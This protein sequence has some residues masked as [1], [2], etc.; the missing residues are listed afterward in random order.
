MPPSLDVHVVSRRRDRSSVERFLSG[1]IDRDA[2]EDRGD[3]ELMLLPVGA[4]GAAGDASSRDWEPAVTLTRA[5][6]RGV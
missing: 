4:S 5:I 6:E 3:E 2:S 1:R